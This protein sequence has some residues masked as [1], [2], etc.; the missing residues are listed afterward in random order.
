[1]TASK[2]KTLF[3]V[4]TVN[5]TLKNQDETKQL[6]DKLEKQLDVKVGSRL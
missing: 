4:K 6:N 2:V 1:M 3:G 5:K